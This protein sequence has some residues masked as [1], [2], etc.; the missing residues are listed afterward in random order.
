MPKSLYGKQQ[1]GEGGGIHVIYDNRS[2]DIE[3]SRER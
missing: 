3:A 2:I 1:W